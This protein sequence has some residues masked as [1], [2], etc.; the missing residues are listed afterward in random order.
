MRLELT[1]ELHHGE[2]KSHVRGNGG[3]GM[4]M[5]TH[6]RPKRCFQELILEPTLGPGQMLVLARRDDRPL[7]VGHHFFT[8]TKGERPVPM[9]W[10]FRAARAAPDRVFYDGPERTLEEVANDASE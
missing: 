6:E 5:M 3:D 10:V 7:S 8:N 9:L 4:F 1:P 2:Y